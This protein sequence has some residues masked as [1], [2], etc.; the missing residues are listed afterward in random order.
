MGPHTRDLVRQVYRT[1]QDAQAVDGNVTMPTFNR[2]LSQLPH[3]WFI[4]PSQKRNYS[5]NPPRA[6]ALHNH[7]TLSSAMVRLLF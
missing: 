2:I 5:S 3:E 1:Q 4:V 7:G 6:S